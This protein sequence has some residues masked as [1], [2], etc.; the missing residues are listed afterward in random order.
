MITEHRKGLGRMAG[1]VALVLGAGSSGYGELSVGGTRPVWSNGAAAATLYAREGAKVVA[2]DLVKESAETTRAIIVGEG[3]EAIAC[4]ADVTKT[5]DVAS[6]VAE[7]VAVYGQIDVLHNNVGVTIMGG[8]LEITEE[9]WRRGLD[10][11]LTSAFL[12]CKHVLPV[13]LAQG[14]GTIVN[15]SSA[16]AVTINE[17]PYASYYASKAGLNHFTRAMALQY[18]AR[19][20]RVNA[21]MPGVMDTPLIYKQISGQYGSVDEMRQARH[22]RSPTGKMGEAWDVA[23]AAL[24]LASDE[25]K[26]VNGVCLAVD[27]GLTCL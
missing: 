25:A 2:V 22:A 1:K 5:D 27:G 6:A 13:M 20:I 10:L 19:G 18:A 16:A 8:P 3:G 7:A 24:F 26:Y 12:A 11:N 4:A 23:Y 17:Y 9:S 15:I 21:I 14:K